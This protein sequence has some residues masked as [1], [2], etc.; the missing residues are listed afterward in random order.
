VPEVIKPSGEII[1]PEEQG[2]GVSIIWT[3]DPDDDPNV[4][5]GGQ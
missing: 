1:T 2:P 3:R 4:E 5:S